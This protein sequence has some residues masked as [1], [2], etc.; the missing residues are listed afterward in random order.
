MTSLRDELKKRNTLSPDSCI[1]FTQKLSK[2][3]EC[4][5]SLTFI[6]K[7]KNKYYYAIETTLEEEIDSHLFDF[8]NTM[9]DWDDISKA[10]QKAGVK[11]FGKDTGVIMRRALIRYRQ[12]KE[13][14]N[15]KNPP[16]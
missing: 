9:F 13:A 4:K 8:C 10:L 3:Q 1:V 14:D 5:L 7:Q 15:I 6:T 12:L 2:S 11:V 16:H